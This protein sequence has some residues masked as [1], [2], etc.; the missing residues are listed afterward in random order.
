M[1]I[2]T[3]INTFTTAT[4]AT[5]NMGSPAILVKK[6]TNRKPPPIPKKNAL[7]YID[8]TI[9]QRSIMQSGGSAY[10]AML[11]WWRSQFPNRAKPV[12]LPF[13]RS[14]RRSDTDRSQGAI[15]WR[16]DDAAS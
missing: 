13:R 15:S 6:G 11:D 12:K 2:G 9:W 16:L 5:K 7:Q 8:Y 10:T 1:E 14:R 4:A 3:T